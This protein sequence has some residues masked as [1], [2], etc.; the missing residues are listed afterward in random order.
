[1]FTEL[2]KTDLQFV[3]S[4]VPKDVRGIMTEKP[5]VLAGGFIRGTIAGEKIADID[6]FTQDVL[7]ADYASLQ[8]SVAR[9]GRIHKTKNAI[10]V[11][12]PP[13][14][15][16]QFI[17][18]WLF[19]KPE[20]VAASFDFTVCQAAIWREPNEGRYMSICSPTF[21]ADLAARRLVYTSPIRNEDAGGSM[22]RVIK[23]IKR[24]YNIQSESLAAVITRM[25][26]GVDMQ[27][28][29]HLAEGNEAEAAR[30]FANILREVDPLTVIDGC[31]LVDEHEI[32]E[33]AEKQTDN[34]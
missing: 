15:P 14:F 8:L 13:R 1:M 28:L 20:Y 34:A 3:L 32:T 5:I 29:H 31:E 17:T 23:Y 19:E 7:T 16:V 22:L 27:K 33:G 2:T 26:R 10:T 9:K 30:M 4:R 6:L 18:R 11:L 21:Y 12:S 25:V 24:G